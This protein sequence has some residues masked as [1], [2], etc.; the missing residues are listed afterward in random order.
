[1]PPMDSLKKTPD[2]LKIVK[3]QSSDLKSKVKYTASDSIR[4]DIITK[5]VYLYGQAAIE[6]E[7]I[8]LKAGFITID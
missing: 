2:T 7:T 5:K 3:K 1:M 4:F 8:H 6:Y